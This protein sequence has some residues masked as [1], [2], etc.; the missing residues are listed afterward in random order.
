[1]A[2]DRSFQF[3]VS[4]Q[5]APGERTDTIVT[6]PGFSTR[7]DTPAAHGRPATK[8]SASPARA[9]SNRPK[10]AIRRCCDM[11]GVSRQAAMS[12][13]RW[14]GR[15]VAVFT[16]MSLLY[17]RKRSFDTGSTGRRVTT[18]E[19]WQNSKP[20][21]LHDKIG[22]LCIRQAKSVELGRSGRETARRGGHTD[23]ILGVGS[24]RLSAGKAAVPDRRT[25]NGS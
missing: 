23:R 7:D 2:A 19:F 9:A 15:V 20:L 18:K 16:S 13:T 4:K 1:M 8:T 11:P 5:A 24:C 3:A 6:S 25:L 10:V 12:L 22:H 14:H 21:F 17:H